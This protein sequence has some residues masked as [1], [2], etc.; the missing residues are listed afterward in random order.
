MQFCIRFPPIHF[1]T[2]VILS[3]SHRTWIWQWNIDS[4]SCTHNMDIVALVKTLKSMFSAGLFDFMA[5]GPR[6]RQ[7]QW[8]TQCPFHN[9][10]VICF[11]NRQLLTV[12]QYAKFNHNSRHN[13]TAIIFHILASVCSYIQLAWLIFQRNTSCHDAESVPVGNFSVKSYVFCHW[14]P[15]LPFFGFT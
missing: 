1:W 5:W 13:H 7:V 15:D 9:T 6:L 11:G 12:Q 4:D 8:T 3:E 10:T 14:M 2:V